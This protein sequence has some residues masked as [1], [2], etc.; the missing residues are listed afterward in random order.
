MRI[1]TQSEKRIEP[2]QTMSDVGIMIRCAR[3]SWVYVMISC[4]PSPGTSSPENTTTTSH[5]FESFVIFLL[6]KYHIFSDSQA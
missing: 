6:I 1:V 4:S 5:Q 2:V 3:D